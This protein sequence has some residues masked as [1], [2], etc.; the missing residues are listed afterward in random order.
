MPEKKVALVTLGCKVNQYESASLAEMFRRRGYQV[1]DFKQPADIYV[2]NTC[3]VTHLGDRKSRQ[4]I[5]RAGRKNPAALIVVTGCYAQTAPGEVLAI[6]GV[7]LVVGTRDKARIVELVEFHRPG[8][9]PLDAVSDVFAGHG[10]AELPA[11]AVT[12]RVRAFLKVQEGCSNYC[13]YCIVPYARGPLKSRRPENVIEE[14]RRLVA[15]GFKELVLT[16]IHTGAYGR[17]Q[18]DGPDLAGLVA[19]VAAVP[20]LL[21]L[22]LSS[23]EPLDVTTELLDVMASRGNVCPHLHIPLQSGD[24]TVL[25]RMR[26][27][28]TSAWFGNLLE[29]VRRKIPGV[30]VTTDVIVGFPGETEEQ[31]ERTLQFVGEMAFSRLHVFKYSP[32][33]G[34]PA[35]AFPGQVPAQVKEERSHR[36]ITLGEALARDFA[37]QYTSRQVT[38][39]AEEPFP[40]GDGLWEG[41]TGNYLR[42]VFPAGPAVRGELVRVQVEE[43]RDNHLKG[44]II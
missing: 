30:A 16:G 12:G 28:Y 3:T 38:V 14:A 36:L 27:H 2:I 26:R 19:R 32:R 4:L 7:D 37:V 43:W 15:D 18:P 6:P 8:G 17:D 44:R 5:R 9:E 22:R 40:A 34:T 33:R 41:Y 1:V 42:V 13:A 25:E 11:T 39:L 29:E 20:G 21:R 23:V 31:F 10:F 24:D 35:A